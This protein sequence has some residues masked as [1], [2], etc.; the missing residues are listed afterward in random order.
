MKPA[1]RKPFLIWLALLVLLA[2]TCGSAFIPLGIWNAIANMTIAVMKAALVVLFFMHLIDARAAYRL[3][4][5]VALFTLA[6]LLGLSNA[7]YSTRVIY[8]APWQVPSGSASV[9]K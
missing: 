5:V 9:V 7:D 3:V 1:Y 2:L 4:G 6:L 8:S